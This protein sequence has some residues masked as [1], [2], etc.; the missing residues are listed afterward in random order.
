[1]SLS[2]FT[3]GMLILA[4]VGLVAAGF[5]VAKS[6]VNRPGMNRAV[7][8]K[9][10][11]RS[12]A[13]LSGARAGNTVI[14]SVAGEGSDQG[15]C[16]LDS[17]SCETVTPAAC[18]AGGGRFQGV[19]IACAEVACT[20]ACCLTATECEDHHSPAT[21]VLQGGIY[22]GDGTDC[23]DPG[24]VNCP[25]VTGA[26][27]LG[28][29]SCEETSP[30]ECP[31]VFLGLGTHCWAVCCSSDPPEVYGACCFGDGSCFECCYAPCEAAGGE[32]RGE[33]TDCDSGACS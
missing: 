13:N 30:A 25:P 10:K 1:M 7:Y 17:G 2:N 23:D 3:R 18:S 33:R 20:G 16:C 31:G 12:K 9:S 4:A 29:D 21:C 8:T 5:P 26:C 14:A 19:G 32:H 11:Y 22:Q 28:D 6:T 27:C 15:A 24:I